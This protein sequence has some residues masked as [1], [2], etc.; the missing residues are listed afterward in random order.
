MTISKMRRMVGGATLCA[1]VLA[2]TIGFGNGVAQAAVPPGATVPAAPIVATD[3]GFAGHRGGY[4][5]HPGHAFFVPRPYYDTWFAPW[6]Y[7]FRGYYR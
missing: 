1:G 6:P 4:G 5:Y 2:A 3:T 7:G